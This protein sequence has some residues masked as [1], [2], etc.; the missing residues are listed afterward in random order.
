MLA[1]SDLLNQLQKHSHA[2][3]ESLLCIYGDPAYLLRRH[4]QALFRGPGL[5]AQQSNFNKSMS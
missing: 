5:T 3:D 4:L 2:P 1:Q